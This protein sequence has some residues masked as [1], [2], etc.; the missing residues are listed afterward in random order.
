MQMDTQLF[1]KVKS[2]VES[3][4]NGWFMKRVVYYCVLPKNMATLLGDA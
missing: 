1:L 3:N 2:S 4:Y